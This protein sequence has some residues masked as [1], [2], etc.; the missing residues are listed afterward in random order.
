MISTKIG[1]STLSVPSYTCENRQFRESFHSYSDIK[2]SRKYFPSYVKCGK[3]FNTVLPLQLK[4]YESPLVLG[5]VTVNPRKVKDPCVLL[6]FAQ[7]NRFLVLGLSPKIYILYRLVRESSRT[8][9]PQILQTWEFEVDIAAVGDLD[10]SQ[11]NVFNYCDCLGCSESE[12]VTYRFEIAEIET[13]NTEVLSNTNESF[14]ATI[15]SKERTQCKKS[16]LGEGET[17]IFADC[18]RVFHPVLP[19]QLTNEEPPVPLAKV[20]IDTHDFRGSCFLITCSAFIKSI[21]SP[22]GFNDLAFRLV[23]T[24]HDNSTR[25]VLN[26]WPF[27]RFFPSAITLDEPVIFRYCDC[28]SKHKKEDCTYTMELVRVNVDEQ[29]SYDIRQVS[30][31]AQ[32]FKSAKTESCLNTSDATSLTC[33]EVTNVHVPNRRTKL[34]IRLATVKVNT[35]KMKKPCILINYS[36]MF[37]VRIENGLG[38]NGNISFRLVRKSRRTGQ[39]KVLEEWTVSLRQVIPTMMSELTMVQP[40]FLS[41]CDCLEDHQGELFT[42]EVQ[43]SDYTVRNIAA[44]IFNPVFSAVVSRGKME[45]NC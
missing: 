33:G 13:T 6:Q 11:P 4:P 41:Y 32:V 15:M 30:M 26:E 16:G 35:E 44:F 18:G 31:T 22:G 40:F 37:E 8:A 39:T 1:N 21:L 38:F 45:C 24:C 14:T 34:P 12:E 7:F 27:R 17:K 42:Y 10:T 3:V 36:S 5:E 19:R 28:L 23:R 25:E 9:C 29:S 43:I 20:T 2:M